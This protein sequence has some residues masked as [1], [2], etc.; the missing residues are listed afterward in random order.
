MAFVSTFEGIH[1]LRKAALFIY[2]VHLERTYDIRDGLSSFEVAELLG[3]SKG[4][5]SNLLSKNQGFHLLKRTT[6][7]GKAGQSR[8]ANYYYLAGDGWKWYL[9]WF[10]SLPLQ[11]WGI[12]AEWLAGLDAKLAGLLAKRGF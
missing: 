6:L 4:D 8:K 9:R 11:R 10:D 5:A 12:T 7:G 2:L 3:I 1:N